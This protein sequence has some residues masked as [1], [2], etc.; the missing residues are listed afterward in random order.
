M[1]SASLPV[2]FAPQSL[3]TAGAGASPP[4]NG[5]A[6]GDVFAA[7]LGATELA[8]LTAEQQAA[9]AELLSDPARAL[10]PGGKVSP[11]AAMRGLL[12]T[13]GFELDP[14]SRA[15]AALAQV[16]PGAERAE[17]G[18]ERVEGGDLASLLAPLCPAIGAP[19]AQSV[20]A[21]QSAAT[22][23][24]GDRGRLAGRAA[25]PLASITAMIAGTGAVGPEEATAP[26]E[27]SPATALPAFEPIVRAGAGSAET[28][29]SPASQRSTPRA[30]GEDR[31]PAAD[32]RMPLAALFAGLESATDAVADVPPLYNEPAPGAGSALDA[33]L[34]AAGRPPMGPVADLVP[35]GRGAAV[36]VVVSIP[37]GERGWDRAFGERI[38]WL[39][40]QQIQAADVKLNP[41]H[42]GPV[43]VRL[44]LTG[45]D[46]SVS[47]T[48]THGAARDAIEQ[49]IPRLREL[50][51]EHQL[52]IVNVDVGQRDASSQASQG[53]RWGEAGGPPAAPQ[54]AAVATD[55]EPMVRVQRSGLPGLVDEYV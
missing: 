20:A 27:S 36:P 45:Q 44:S 47:F 43:E 10:Q 30:G 1:D 23:D 16:A 15:A 54:P 21:R 2:L 25:S 34:A 40:G 3:T 4:P 41:P 32:V 51:A 18:A 22:T 24:P 48:V 28:A 53:E 46:A 50:F 11:L 12:E 17:V 19:A 14:A 35:P 49:A 26:P 39:V 55:S 9:L 7:V 13:L 52:Q 42:L 31:S 6:V 8:G 33:T 37:V 29:A 5:A 38:V